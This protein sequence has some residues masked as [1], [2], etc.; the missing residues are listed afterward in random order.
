MKTTMAV[1]AALLFAVFQSV[2][3][4]IAGP[5]TNPA[6]GHDYYLLTP[7]SWP[8][9]E[10]EAE[11]LGATLAI[12]RNASEQKWI[13][14]TFGFYDGGLRNLWI[15]LHRTNSGGAFVWVDGSPVEYTD[16]FSGE[17]NNL[18]GDETCI[19]MRADNSRP[20]TWNDI[21][22]A[23]LFNGIVE[24]SEEIPITEK[25]RALVGDWYMSGRADH[26]CHITE[27]GDALYVINEMNRASRIVFN[28]KGFLFLVPPEI[29]GE[30]VE[31]KILWS[32]GTWWS[33]KPMDYRSDEAS[34]SGIEP[35]TQ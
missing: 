13:Y 15:G 27:T 16:W 12:V 25:Q 32:D 26:P 35:E 19:Q 2:A 11:N 22:E 7:D 10:T 5:I 14:S 31:D 24:V 21:N 33:R 18:G 4:I 28:R 30:V 17:P 20:G 34:L 29:Y 8:A 23:A 1:F 3:G 9:S 6:N